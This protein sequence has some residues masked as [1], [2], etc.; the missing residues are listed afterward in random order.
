M[1][2]TGPTQHLSD[3][4]VISCCLSLSVALFLQQSQPYTGSF[5]ATANILATDRGHTAALEGVVQFCSSRCS[6][7]LLPGGGIAAPFSVTH[8]CM[9]AALANVFAVAGPGR[10]HPYPGV[11]PVASTK[12][13]QCSHS[14]RISLDPVGVFYCLLFI[15]RLFFNPRERLHRA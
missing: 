9:L 11:L 1:Q 2:N 13:S 6:V 14:N 3:G 4:V 7:V 5:S 8:V 15:Q 10:L 12:A